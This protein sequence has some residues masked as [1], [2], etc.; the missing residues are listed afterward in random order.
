MKISGVEIKTDGGWLKNYTD[1][2]LLVAK[3]LGLANDM[4]IT[5][6]H[7]TVLNF[8]REFYEEYGSLPE[9]HQIMKTLGNFKTCNKKYK[10]LF[11]HGLDERIYKI[12]GV[13]KSSFNPHNI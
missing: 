3:M 9:K 1:W 6:E 12:A 4:Q 8:I 5:D 7:E 13:P 2:N 11:P 10:E